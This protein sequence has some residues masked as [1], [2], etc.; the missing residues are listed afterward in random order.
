MFGWI[1]A[2]VW[3]CQQTSLLK[4]NKFDIRVSSHTG[5]HQFLK[6]QEP[7]KISRRQQVDTKQILYGGRTNIWRHRETV[8]LHR[9]LAPGICA[10]LLYIYI[11]YRET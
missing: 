4:R 5:V 7:P 3:V 1:N 2:V 11:I 8:I 6:T 10:P 9:N